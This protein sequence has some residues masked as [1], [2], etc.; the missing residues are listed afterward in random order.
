MVT[1]LTLPA[2]L[3]SGVLHAG[4]AD[5]TCSGWAGITA[6]GAVEP[7]GLDEL[8]GLAGSP[9]QDALWAVND[10]GG[11]AVLYAIA[12]DGS[13]LGIYGVSGAENVDWED[14]AVGTCDGCACLY[15]G[16][17]GDQEGA[18][19][20]PVVWQVRE[21]DL[22]AAGE[23][24]LTAE[25]I[26]LVYPDGAWDAE[27]LLVDPSS[28][29]LFVIP[30]SEDVV[31]VY[32]L[33]DPTPGERGELEVVGELDLDAL[34]AKDPRITGGAVSPGGLRVVLRTNEDVLLFVA[35]EGGSVA[36]ALAEAPIVLEAPAGQDGEAV[37]WTADGQ[38]VIL[39]GEGVGATLWGLSC[40]SFEETVTE[41]S[42]ELCAEEGKD[43]GCGCGSGGRGGIVGIVVAGLALGGRRRVLA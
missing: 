1:T 31:N 7:T 6:L 22:S 32:R 38:T 11:G 42:P 34:G 26:G 3:L 33:A 17:L 14:L 30:K 20:E 25:A 2:F 24:T 43:E 10:S 16:D 40:L 29:E 4:S 19:S 9:A 13:E 18:R 27:T 35:P 8:S 36:E 5:G 21:P 37:A 28:G 15:V 39:A 41:S 23:S 12:E